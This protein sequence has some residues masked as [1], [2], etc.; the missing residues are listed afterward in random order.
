[1]ILIMTSLTNSALDD[2][3]CFSAL[4]ICMPES[5][6]VYHKDIQEEELESKESVLLEELAIGTVHDWDKKVSEVGFEPTPTYVDQNTQLSARYAL[7]SGALDRSAILT[8]PTKT[9]KT[10][11]INRPT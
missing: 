5:V 7:E 6:K 2:I 8:Q 3:V 9:D 4:V 11:L 10:S 1:M